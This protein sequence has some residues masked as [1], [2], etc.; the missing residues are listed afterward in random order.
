MHCNQI[1]LRLEMH[2]QRDKQ[3]QETDT[4]IVARIHMCAHYNRGSWRR[5]VWLRCSTR[6]SV[7]WLRCGTKRSSLRWLPVKNCLFVS[8]LQ[9]FLKR[10]RQLKII[11]LGKNIVFDTIQGPIR[12]QIILNPIQNYL[13]IT[14]LVHVSFGRSVPKKYGDTYDAVRTVHLIQL[15]YSV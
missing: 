3:E 5:V 11:V 6:R 14:Q 10:K 9:F 2:K 7:S 4:N 1:R 15:L 12:Y 13:P 8:S